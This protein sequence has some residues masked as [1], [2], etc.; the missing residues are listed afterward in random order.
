[1]RGSPVAGLDKELWRAQEFLKQNH[2]HF[3]PG[4]NEDLAATAIWGTQQAN[5]FEGA[6]Y[7]GVFG[8][9]YG[10]GPGV[11]RSGDAIKHGNAA[12][13]S[14]CG[15]VLLITGDDHG[16]KSSSLAHQSEYAMIDAMIPVLNPAGIQEILDFGLYGWAI[17][18]F[19][20][21]W[22]ALK[23]ITELV[24]SS[25]SV[26]V[27]PQRVQIKPPGNFQMPPEGLNIRWPD[28]PVEQEYRLHEYK[29]KAAVAFARANWLNRVL[30][31]GPGARFGI[32][33][34]GKSYL[35]VRQV[36]EE[37]GI[38]EKSAADIGIRLLK[39]GMTWPLDPGE[40]R[41]FAK[42]LEEILVVEEKRPLIESQIKEILYE[43]RHDARPII[44]GKRDETGATL[45]PSTKG[46]TPEI[47]ARAV[48]GRLGRF[49]SS[50]QIRQRIA[51]L[52]L[53]Q[54]AAQESKT[55]I[56][57]I[58]Y[59]C[60]GCPHNSSTRVP[61]GSR[62]IAGVGCHYMVNWMDR[63]TSTF[64]H[65]GGEGVTWIGQAPFTDTPH[66]F[67]N[68]GDGTY[69][70]SG[71]L[72]IRAALAAKVNI[73]FKILFNDAVAMTGG[74]PIDGQLTVPQLT[75]QLHAEGVHRIAVVTDEPEK[76]ADEHTFA[77]GITVHHR[78]VLDKIQREF[79]ELSGVS[80]IVYDQACAAEKR[81]KRKWG[82]AP[83]PARRIFI[84]EMVCEGCG[85]CGTK[86][87]CLSVIPVA[88]EFGSKRA[89]DQSSCNK[90]YTCLDGFCPSFVTVHGGRIRRHTP[91]E[92]DLEGGGGLPDP[93]TP[94]LN[95]PYDIVITG[96]GGTGVVTTGAL[97]GM[98]AHIEGKG[99]SILDMAGLAQK[100]GAVVSHLRIA[101]RPEDIHSVQISAGNA[102]LLL[103]CDLVVS[104]AQDVLS[105]TRKGIT[106]ALVNSHETAVG[107]FTQDPDLIFPGEELRNSI[108]HAVGPEHMRTLDMTSLASTV[109]GDTIM[110]NVI[111]LGYA[112]QLGHIPLSAESIIRTI[113]ISRV[114]VEENKRA[115]FLGRLAAH[116]P[117]AL[118]E[119]LAPPNDFPAGA[120]G[121]SLENV[122]ARRAELLTAYQNAAYTERYEH[123]VRR[124]QR[125]EAEKA[126]G[127]TELT[128]AAARNYFK[129]LAYKDEYEVARLY[130]DGTFLEQLEKQFEGDFRFTFHFAPPLLPSRDPETGELRKRTFGRWM[131]HALKLMARFKFLRGTALD[132]FGYTAE[133]R[134]ERR[135]IRDFEARMEEVLEHLDPENHAAAV[136][137]ADN[138]KTIRGFGHIKMAQA[139]IFRQKEK[140]LLDTF[141]RMKNV[142]VALV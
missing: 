12:G 32:V 5:L 92:I 11:D 118:K 58:P 35:D 18:R 98:A 90:D 81:R 74:Q 3:Q 80:A 72:A 46:L 110:A 76:Y 109:L 89:I 34:A 130:S 43:L 99:C 115:F 22:V 88:T 129:L 94:E 96:V 16:S 9:W 24:N 127:R 14:R 19:S 125:I 17:S 73:T 117:D 126:E 133:R 91:Q 105:K 83:D 53:H 54:K 114:A 33:T 41:Q 59:F 6:R 140:E 42:G 30:I 142:K 113:E 106:H 132:I 20:G 23:A 63:N 28:T 15:G 67:Q 112:Y 107:T 8:M 70:H 102:R 52:D 78:K 108:A 36:L 137:I 75:R 40:I 64:T 66:I 101:G 87:N 120:E 79:R 122:I 95:A 69:F 103:G 45:L 48:A 2:I 139:E 71:S 44:V 21:C 37:F 141:Y 111:M 51:Y 86:S 26:Y 77:P 47:I 4:I 82:A 119:W 29:I 50:D 57:R 13:S 104:A 62:A 128:E 97:L 27:D 49:H 121:D 39:V 1:Y 123:F 68:L 55:A 60:S 85:D 138:Y 135:L 61:E 124:V 134:M 116:N 131:M 38:D 31:D 100:G 25:A 7:D 65:M 136:E 10:K 93:K 84:N 56:Q